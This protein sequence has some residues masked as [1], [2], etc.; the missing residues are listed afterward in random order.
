MPY[1][2][3]Q[4]RVLGIFDLTT[5]SMATGSTS[6][7]KEQTSGETQFDSGFL[8]RLKELIT[9]IIQE[10]RSAGPSPP[11][12]TPTAHHHNQNHSLPR[13][14]LDFPKWDEDDPSG[15]V[16]RVELFFHFHGTSEAS[17]VD[18]ASIHLEGETV[19]WYD[20]FEASHGMPT[21]ATFVEGPFCM[22]RP[23]CI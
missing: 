10:E 15:W 20:W 1:T 22:I 6:L 18:I 3:N 12:T 5:Y 14:K 19:Q 2:R 7:G 11:R 4:K 17:R 8:K 16:S 23:L 9:Q 21:W 13:M